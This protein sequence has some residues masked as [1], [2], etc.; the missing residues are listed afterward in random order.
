[1]KLSGRT[2]LIAGA[3]M[4]SCLLI[5]NKKASAQVFTGGEFAVNFMGNITVD[6][7]PIV[8]YKI[9]NFRTGIS[10]VVMYTATGN[11]SGDLSYGGRVFAEYLIYQGVFG[12]A[13]FEALN[14]GH[15]DWT[16]LKIQHNWVIGAPIGVG[17]E[18]EITKGVWF[19]TM[20]LYDALLDLNLDQTSAKANPSIRGGIVYQF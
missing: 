15:Y 16:A 4:I 11:T 12:H 9:Q 17:Y 2:L 14:T 1:M 10:P 20:V 13:E 5:P 8:G 18:K 19:K 6:I 7:A 3:L